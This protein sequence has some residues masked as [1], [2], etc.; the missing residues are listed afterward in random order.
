VVVFKYIY[1]SVLE[2]VRV[3]YLGWTPRDV[4]G[5]GSRGL[6]K[7]RRQ[8]FVKSYLV[9]FDFIIPSIKT[10][11]SPQYIGYISSRSM[12]ACQELTVGHRQIA[13]LVRSDEPKLLGSGVCE[14]GTFRSRYSNEKARSLL[15]YTKDRKMELTWTFDRPNPRPW[16]W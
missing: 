8:S 7:G 15:D 6:R 12:V 16:A 5:Q 2:E 1:M 9:S 4:V 3:F 13:Q 10:S 11:M 14:H